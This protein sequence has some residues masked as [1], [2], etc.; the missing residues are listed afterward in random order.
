MRYRSLYVCA[1]LT[2][3]LVLAAGCRPESTDPSQRILGRWQILDKQGIHVPHSFF[4]AM[5]DDLE[6]REDGT[7]WGLLKWPPHVGPDMRLNATAE[8]ALVGQDQI[9]LLGDCRHQGPCTGTYTITW[10]GTVLQIEG[11]DVL[12]ELERVGPPSKDPPQRIEG[13][14]PTPTPTQRP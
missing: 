2:L 9:E 10:K 7:V 4:W 13:P 1:F 3:L 8:Y 5:M 6:F 14:S 11:E 12:L